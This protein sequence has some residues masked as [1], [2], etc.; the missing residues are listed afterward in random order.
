[1]N[2]ATTITP[3]VLL[4]AVL[5]LASGGPL[6]AQGFTFEAYGGYASLSRASKSADAVFGSSGGGTYGGAVGYAFESGIYV[7]AGARYFSKSG[8]QVFVADASSP[9]FSLG[10]PLK[11]KIV[12]IYATVGYRF[13]LG[14]SSFVPYV[15]A[16]GGITSYDEESTIAGLTDTTSQTKGAGHVVAGLEFGGSRMRVGV[17]AI[18]SI[19]PNSIGVGGV[20]RVYGEKDIGGFTV[21]GKVILGR[22]R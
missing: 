21:L 13:R 1:M 10:H 19:V 17:E 3:C 8:T 11:V 2:R 4:A 6:H 22:S 20:S 15:G 9:A 14:E 12:P 16:G 7:S 5:L 18:Y